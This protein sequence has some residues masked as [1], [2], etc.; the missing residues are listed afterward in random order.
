MRQAIGKGKPFDREEFDK[1]MDWLDQWVWVYDFVGSAESRKVFQ[2]WEYAARKYG[3]HHF[4]L[5]SLMRL[6]DVPGSDFDAQ[7]GLM[8]RLNDFAKRHR[9]HVHL[10]AHSRKPDARHPKEKHWP[11][12]LDISGSSDI[13]NGAWNVICMWRN[14]DKQNNSEIIWQELRRRG[15]ST[16]ERETLQASLAKIAQKN[17]AMF[18]VQKQRTAGEFPLHRQLWFDHGSNGSWQFSAEPGRPARVYA[19]S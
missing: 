19:G 6:Q 15:L 1:A 13:P 9:V 17:D 3:I 16:D 2:C 18:I 14:E 10:V 12:E 11:G 4:V 5:D 7:K 8:N